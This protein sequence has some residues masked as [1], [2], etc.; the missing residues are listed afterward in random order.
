MLHVRLHVFP[1]IHLH[2]AFYHATFALYKFILA[3]YR[4][5]LQL[6]KYCT[7]V[8]RCLL[9]HIIMWFS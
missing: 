8:P 1:R 2:Y 7:H 3:H 9:W 4:Y 5:M 6:H